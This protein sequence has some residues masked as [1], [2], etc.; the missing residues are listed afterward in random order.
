MKKPHMHSAAV[1]FHAQTGN[2]TLWTDIDPENPVCYAATQ[3]NNASQSYLEGILNLLQFFE[4]THIS[5]GIEIHIDHLHTYNM[6]TR[7]LP[8]WKLHSW[9]TSQ[10][11]PAP[12][13]GLLKQID[14][15]LQKRPKIAFR[16]YSREFIF[17]DYPLR[18]AKECNVPN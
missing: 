7:F 17:L 9:H 3:P 8:K 2:T 16:N 15:I 11:K 13:S 4:T 1:T 10:N 6:L 14:H 18:R 5:D 12:H